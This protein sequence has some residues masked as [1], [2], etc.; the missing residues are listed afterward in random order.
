VSIT[1]DT[2]DWTWVLD[3]P[4][5]ECGF[6]ASAID[7]TEVSDRLRDNAAQWRRVLSS[8]DVRQRPRPDTWSPLEYGC[9]VRD[10][11]AL[12]L[13]RLTLMLDQDDPAYPNWDQ[14]VTAVEHAYDA[15]DP[16]VVAVELVAAAEGLA[17]AFDSVTGAQW[18][19]TGSR[20]DGAAFTI[21][22]FSRYFLHDV[23]HHLW[24]VRDVAEAAP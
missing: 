13:Q 11:C 8:A 9:H 19:R 14:D 22:T 10:V 5:S 16:K 20:S 15:Q 2:K 17:A 18:Q 24:D 4:C 3:R 12:Y 7:C 6:D 21:D 1:P 23:V